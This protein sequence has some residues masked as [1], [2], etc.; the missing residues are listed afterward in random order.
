MPVSDEE[1]GEA[2]REGEEWA[3]E[4]VSARNDLLALRLVLEFALSLEP[5]ARWPCAQ[6]GR[7][8]RERKRVLEAVSDFEGT[9]YHHFAGCM[10][11]NRFNRIFDK[12]RAAIA[13]LALSGWSAPGAANDH[14]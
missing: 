3:A 5:A 13:K 1:Y 7:L 11:C 8:G 2:L 4:A 9:S 12:A 14:E 10:K 6:C